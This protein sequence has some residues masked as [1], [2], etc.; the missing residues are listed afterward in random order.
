MPRAASLSRAS[1]GRYRIVRP[2]AAGGTAMVH[3]VEEVATGAVWVAKSLHLSA[4]PE[5]KV[6]QLFERGAEVLRGLDHPGIPRFRELIRHEGDGAADLWLIE[7]YIPGR[8]LRRI[9][10]RHPTAPLDKALRLAAAVLSILRYLHTRT[11]PVLHRDVKPSNIILR[12]DGRVV[13]I[14]FGSVQEVLRQATLGGSTVAGTYGYMPPEQ[15]MGKAEPASDVYAVGATLLHLVTGRGPSELPVRDMR[16]D[17]SQV[18]SGQPDLRALLDRLMDPRVERRVRS[19]QEAHAM[20]MALLRRVERGERG[21]E[22]GEVSAAALPDGLDAR[23]LH[24]GAGA[25]C[26][27]CGTTMDLVALGAR[28]TEVDVCPAC[29]GVWLDA[30][31]IGELIERPLIMRPEL[32]EIGRNVRA[33]M[34]HVPDAVVYRRCARCSEFM[35]RV[36]FA[37]VSGVVVDE[38]RAHGTWLDRGELERIRQ[39]VSIGGLELSESRERDR[40]RQ[41]A[42]SQGALSASLHSAQAGSASRPSIL[43]LIW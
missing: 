15:Y 30:R 36:N 1:Q 4:V 29:A 33:T 22:S 10:E 11:P 35:T 42:R 38:C 37:T 19:A 17:T 6:W 3:I 5:W 34:K 9:L 39:F 40:I 7:E 43:D 25:T 27:G 16:V 26:P 13:L 41:D 12:P 14:D 20:V 24:A 31:E 23:V 2:L 28:E 8:D 32:R 21:P 18:L